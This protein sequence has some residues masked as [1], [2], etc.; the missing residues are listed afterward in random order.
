MKREK[1]SDPILYD[2][3][4]QSIKKSFEEKFKINDD[5]SDNEEEKKVEDEEPNYFRPNFNVP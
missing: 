1:P 4:K 5:K 2:D 3:K